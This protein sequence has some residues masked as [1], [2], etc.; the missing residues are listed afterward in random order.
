MRRPLA[1]QSL[2][3]AGFT[4][5]E[6]LVVIAIIGTLVG[7]LLPAV[8]AARETARRNTC[9]NNLKQ[10]VLSMMNYDASLSKLPGYVNELPHQGSP[11]LP[12][13]SYS[14]G[15][16]ASWMVMAFPYIEQNALWDRWTQSFQSAAPSGTAGDV[17]DSDLPELVNFQ[18]PSDAAENVGLPSTSYVGNAG[19]G[20]QGRPAADDGFEFAANGV[21]FDL[22]RK[23]AG[24]PTAGWSN[25]PDGREPGASANP[26]PEVRMSIDYISSGDGTSRTMMLSENLH[27]L[28][29]TYGFSAN[30]KT[31][32]DAKHHFGFVFHNQPIGLGAQ[33]GTILNGTPQQIQ[34][35]NGGLVAEVQTP[36][37][38]HPSTQ[39]A[40]VELEEW[41]A[42]P[43]SNHPGGVNMGF[44][45]GRV[46]FVGD[47]IDYRVYA[48][49]MTTKYKRS[50]YVNGGTADRLLP[51]P[52]DADLQ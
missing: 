4:L 26:A 42:Y 41:M 17:I 20:F 32:A 47:R 23:A 3:R 37:Q 36:N 14:V 43:S 50:S 18:C 7:L 19:W 51:Q 22:N 16:R 24:L 29:Y 44:C 46:Q 2:A 27:A 30:T 45:D 1:A 38:Y 52:T 5:V 49:S 11:R 6:L 39:P 31:V 8:Q 40:Q 9:Q 15:R 21:F 48:Q 25:E 33:A 34:T 35:I 10:L 13:G 28:S 12:D